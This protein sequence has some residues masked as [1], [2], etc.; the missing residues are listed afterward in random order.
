[1]PEILSVSYAR[2]HC[3]LPRCCASA[4]STRLL[5]CSTWRSYS[6]Q[7]SV[8]FESAYRGKSTVRQPWPGGRLRSEPGS[9]YRRL[10]NGPWES[11]WLRVDGSLWY[12]ASRPGAGSSSRSTGSLTPLACASSTW[13]SSTTDVQRFGHA[14]R[15]RDLV[16]ATSRYSRLAREQAICRGRFPNPGSTYESRYCWP[17]LTPL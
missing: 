5:Q 10:L 2:S 16:P 17:C 11:S 7:I 1:M 14:A 15:L 13:P 6:E 8:R 12:S 3:R 9:H 4:T